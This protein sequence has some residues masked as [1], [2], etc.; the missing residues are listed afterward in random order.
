M[1]KKYLTLFWT[2]LKWVLDFL[3]Y[4]P[5]Y[6]LHDSQ[7]P[8]IGEDVS[9]CHYEYSTPAGSLEDV[10]CAVCLCKM[11]EGG[12]EIR[13]LRCDHAFHRDCL[14]RWLGFKNAIC[15]L[16]RQSVG[17]RRAVSELGAEVL[18]FQFCSVRNDDRETWW[19]R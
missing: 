8:I 4:Y 18:F 1:L 9:I 17:L 7:M 5:F 19:L 16:C 15:P 10:D 3:L 13:V 14:D 11:G 12:K 6:K 2:H